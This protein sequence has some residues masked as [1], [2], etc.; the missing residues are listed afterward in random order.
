M[1]RS[2]SLVTLASRAVAVQTPKRTLDGTVEVAVRF[3]DADQAIGF[4]MAVVQASRAG[5]AMSALP[6]AV[7]PDAP[8]V[9]RLRSAASEAFGAAAFLAPLPASASGSQGSHVLVPG[10]RLM[11]G[12]PLS[13]EAQRMSGTWR[14]VEDGGLVARAIASTDPGVLTALAQL[15]FVGTR[16]RF[17]RSD[18]LIIA[19]IPDGKHQV[20][21]LKSAIHAVLRFDVLV[22]YAVREFQGKPASR[23]G[24]SSPGS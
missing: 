4:A 12:D 6:E 13:F 10:I 3:V 16:G 22:S 11:D 23:R 7:A 20:D 18:S 21:S 8:E 24:K 2:N 15:A 9:E 19:D 1:S 5:G 17:V 14:L